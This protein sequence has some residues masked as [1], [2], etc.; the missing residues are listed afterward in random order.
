MSYK[1][2]ILCAKKTAAQIETAALYTSAGIAGL[3]FG[4]LTYPTTLRQPRRFEQSLTLS[5]GGEGGQG[6]RTKKYLFPG[7]INK[8]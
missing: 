5:A 4:M 6:S 7:D 3:E 2:E 8:M 1:S